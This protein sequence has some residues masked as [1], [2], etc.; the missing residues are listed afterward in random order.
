LNGHRPENLIL[1]G[2]RRKIKTKQIVDK[3]STAELRQIKTSTCRSGKK[4][5]GTATGE[6]NY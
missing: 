5:K 4:K 2:S 1:Q 6:W 3:H